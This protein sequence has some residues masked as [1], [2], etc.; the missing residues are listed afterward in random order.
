MR[1]IAV[2]S[3]Q[4]DYHAVGFDELADAADFLLGGY[5]DAQL[6]PCGT[7][8]VLTDETIHV[9]TGL[10]EPDTDAGELIRQTARTYFNKAVSR[11]QE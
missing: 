7:Y 6:V 10:F 2:F 5:Q 3:Q 11:N 1:F 8:D 9:D 4:N